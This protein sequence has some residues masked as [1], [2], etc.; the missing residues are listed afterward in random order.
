MGYLFLAIALAFM[1]T[2]SL[3]NM[4]QWVYIIHI[5]EMNGTWFDPNE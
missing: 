5:S 1:F 4:M 2:H 3:D